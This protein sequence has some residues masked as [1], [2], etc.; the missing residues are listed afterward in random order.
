MKRFPLPILSRLI[1]RRELVSVD[2]RKPKK[3]QKVWICDADW[4]G[5]A[6]YELPAVFDGMDY[7]GTDGMKYQGMSLWKPR[8]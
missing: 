7:V 8:K 2:I 1:D 3:G 6:D 4:R 5:W